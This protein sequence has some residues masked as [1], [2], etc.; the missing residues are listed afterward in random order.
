M[1]EES[2]ICWDKIDSDTFPADSFCAEIR[3]GK[4]Y[5]HWKGQRRMVDNHPPKAGTI[6]MKPEPLTSECQRLCQT[7]PA[8]TKGYMMDTIESDYQHRIPLAGDPADKGHAKVWEFW[9]YMEVY[10]DQADMCE[11]CA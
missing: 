2:N 8:N 6:F 9:N 10:G 7:I 1:E 11:G 4:D 5:Y 3:H